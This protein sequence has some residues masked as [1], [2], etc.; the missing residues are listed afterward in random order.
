MDLSEGPNKSR[1]KNGKKTTVGRSQRKDKGE[2]L[3]SGSH[4]S[5]FLNLLEFKLILVYC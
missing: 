1:Y 3:S 5:Q 2:K 4:S